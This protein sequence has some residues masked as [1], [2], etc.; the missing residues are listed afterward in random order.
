MKRETIETFQQVLEETRTVFYTGL[1]DDQARQFMSSLFQLSVQVNPIDAMSSNGFRSL[2]RMYNGDVVLR[3]FINRLYFNF[4]FVVGEAEWQAVTKD[5]VAALNIL[6][7][8]ANLSAVSRDYTA[9]IFTANEIETTL[10]NNRPLV[11]MFLIM[12]FLRLDPAKS[13]QNIP[14]GSQRP[15]YKVP[16]GS[17]R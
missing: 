17:E 3:N 1:K 10:V 14:P 12:R 7:S 16:P 2:L 4:V 15:H 11:M 8:Q 5:L 6:E 9:S 13:V